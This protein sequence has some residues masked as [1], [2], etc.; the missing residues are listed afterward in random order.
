[1]FTLKSLRSLTETYI[2]IVKEKSDKQYI[3]EA[4]KDDPNTPGA[5]QANTRGVLHE[6]LVGKHLNGNEHMEKH[7]LV[8]PETKV[9]E[10]PKQAH[11][12]LR[13]GIHGSDYNRIKK[14]AISA[15]ETIKSNIAKSHPGHVITGVF[16]TSKPGDTKKVTGIS[17]TQ[18]QDSSDAYITT[19]HPKTGEVVHHGQSLKISNTANKNIASSS[20]GSESSGSTAKAK[21]SEH[22]KEIIAEFP[23]L[24]NKGPKERRSILA[25]DP[26]MQ[27][28][29]KS[30]N[31]AFLHG[32]AK[33]HAEELQGHLKSGNYAHVVSHLR[34]VLHAHKTPA[35]EAGHT[36]TKVT[37][38]HTAAGVQNHVS[39]PHK[40][41]EHIL[42]DPKNISVV[43]NGQGVDFL[44]KGKKFA[45]Q[46]HKFGS[47]SDPLSSLKSAGK[48]HHD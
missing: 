7:E 8:D 26:H 41:Y 33:T 47:Q 35:Q 6:L 39:H 25:K 46:S 42:K 40:D 11:D 44:H 9:R 28:T 15:A 5:I 16:H 23:H 1:M 19:K 24:A 3:S 4:K 10:T 34:D 14:G 12:R 13:A 36:F 21:H 2:S 22:K 27:K 18:K 48:P 30:R 20:L 38:Y 29:V 17:A 43:H 45:T 37:T 31:N 32:V